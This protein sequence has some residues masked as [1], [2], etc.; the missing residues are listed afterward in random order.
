LQCINGQCGG[1]LEHDVVEDGAVFETGRTAV[2]YYK[3]QGRAATWGSDVARPWRQGVATAL[4]A[5]R[6]CRG[7]DERRG[8]FVAS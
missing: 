1:V 6:Q 2:S 5:G 4:E 3:V 7:G 8:G